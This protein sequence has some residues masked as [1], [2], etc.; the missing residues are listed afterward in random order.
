[1]QELESDLEEAGGRYSELTQASSQRAAE[2]KERATM[3]QEE[4]AAL[5]ESVKA[6]QVDLLVWC[7]RRWWWSTHLGV[8]E[9]QRGLR[10]KWRECRDALNVQRRGTV[11]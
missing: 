11:S 8:W 6:L 9:G 4:I 7:W 2:E 10:A 1:M 5:K 3:L